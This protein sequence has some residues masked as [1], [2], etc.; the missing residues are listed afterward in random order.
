M[1]I[2][3]YCLE[4]HGYEDGKL[5]GPRLLGL[6]LAGCSLGF[7]S[8]VAHKGPADMYYVFVYVYVYVYIYV[9]DYGHYQSV[10]FQ[11]RHKTVTK[12]RD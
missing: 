9:Y 11:V 5:Q 12:I 4:L 1:A 10:R 3:Q 7:N 2:L 6:E 8:L